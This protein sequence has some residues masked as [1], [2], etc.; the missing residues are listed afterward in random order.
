MKL[1][2]S[3]LEKHISNQLFE[4]S[5]DSMDLN[6][7]QIAGGKL[8]CTLSVEHAAG[9]YRIHG[10][11]K[12]KVLE[13][14]DRCL[15]KFEEELESLLDVILTG[16][17]ELINYDNVDVIHFADTDEFID[18]NPI[19]HDLVLLAEP[20]QRICN[21]SCMGLCLNCGINLNESTCS[22]NSTEDNSRW[23]ALKNL[24]N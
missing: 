23:D 19:I 12:G 11:L 15:T 8:T 24:K 16:N 22:C 3:D 2:R 6:D 4:I 20:F 13:K 21:E 7:L 14:C 10:P 5:A 18:L 1:F 9:G 17:D